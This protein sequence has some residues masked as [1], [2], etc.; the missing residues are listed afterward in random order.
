MPLREND[1]E[2][3]AVFR[4]AKGSLA[5][6]SPDVVHSHPESARIKKGFLGLFGFNPVVS[7]MIDVTIVPIKHV[8]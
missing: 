7:D 2:D 4:R 1:E 6:F 5:L 3:A 8:K